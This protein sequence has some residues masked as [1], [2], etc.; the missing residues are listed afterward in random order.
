MRCEERVRRRRSHGTPPELDAQCHTANSNRAS[1][2]SDRTRRREKEREAR[3][4]TRE[5]RL[6]GSL[7]E[8]QL[9][10]IKDGNASRMTT[11]F[12]ILQ[13]WRQRGR[14]DAESTDKIT[15]T[16]EKSQVSME[17]TRFTGVVVANQKEE[18]IKNIPRVEEDGILLIVPV[19]INGK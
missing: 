6:V 13:S 16:Q 12:S 3:E 18:I 17:D 7:L 8:K 5:Q 15:N 2:Q 19:K 1:R 14:V 9:N 11:T 10:P 4:R